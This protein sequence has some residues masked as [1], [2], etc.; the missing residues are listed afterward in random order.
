M[1]VKKI[2]IVFTLIF[3]M[4]FPAFALFGCG[5]LYWSGWN[6]VTQPTCEQAGEKVRHGTN[7][8]GYLQIQAIDPLGHDLLWMPDGTGYSAPYGV[9]RR[10]GCSYIE[11]D[12]ETSLA[13]S[14]RC[15]DCKAVQNSPYTPR[16]NGNA[17][18]GVFWEVPIVRVGDSPMPMRE[19][20]FDDKDTS[21]G[22]FVV[23]S[24]EQLNSLRIGSSSMSRPAAHNYS[25]GF[26][27][28]N[29]LIFLT[30]TT[31]N[32]ET[33]FLFFYALVTDS[34]YFYPVFGLSG[35][36]MLT[37]IGR[38]S[39]VIE[40]PRGIVD[41][42]GAGSLKMGPGWY[43][44]W[45]NDFDG[46]INWLCGKCKSKWPLTPPSATLGIRASG[47]DSVLEQKN[48]A[49]SVS[50][51]RLHWQSPLGGEHKVYVQRS[52]AGNFEYLS[53][54]YGN[55]GIDLL[56]LELAEGVNTIKVEGLNTIYQNGG[57]IRYYDYYVIERAS[58]DIGE[59][60]SLSINLSSIASKPNL[61]WGSASTFYVYVKSAGSNDFKRVKDDWDRE[62][63][64]TGNAGVAVDNF[65]FK[66]GTNIIKTVTY[67][68]LNGKA[69]RC[70]AEIP[71]TLAAETKVN[72]NFIVGGGGT[73]I[74]G[75]GH[76]I[77]WAGTKQLYS[78]FIKCPDSNEFKP[79]YGDW[80]NG[81]G[82]GIVR[83]SNI[84]DWWG[85]ELQDG[86]HTLRVEGWQF[87]GG[88][89]SKIVSEFEFEVK[90]QKKSDIRFS[91]DSE[92]LR[93]DYTKPWYIHSLSVRRAGSD[94]YQLITTLA[95]G[96]LN[97][98]NGAELKILG[99]TPGANV[100]RVTTAWSL[101]GNIL[102]RH[103]GYYTIQ[104]TV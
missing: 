103:A 70:V 23:D 98:W 74:G 77:G 31:P 47:D 71:L 55:G 28:D 81:T 85:E 59:S 61:T 19:W 96:G 16:H 57:F 37:A 58:G 22:L 48:Y 52:G 42:Y 73:G 101:N 18:N 34:Q 7:N 56:S 68:F 45:N 63:S 3:C 24:F 69:V 13:L 39:F 89:L 41:N 92:R 21:K 91:L 93:W 95:T 97:E 35:H 12:Y 66:A 4:G 10:D 100:V 49:F 78:A 83:F 94:N 76:F 25:P 46:T 67:R 72:Y 11:A 64:T 84:A 54:S 87:S 2:L 88:V 14:E 53:D 43:A 102:T 80:D 50:N 30:V 79:A 26:F 51:D 8:K 20:G 99:L 60:Y 65:S 6:V 33:Q 17:E 62:I 27:D 32:L 104:L 44:N 86:A 1:K 38:R 9:C 90:T 15:E 40:V 75:G 5:E 29:A 36:S 82:G